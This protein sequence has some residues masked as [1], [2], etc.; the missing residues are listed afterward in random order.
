LQIPPTSTPPT[1]PRID[2]LASKEAQLRAQEDELRQ[3]IKMVKLGM[4]ML[5]QRV[6]TAISMLVASSLFGFALSSGE[7]SKIGAASLFT[8]IVFIPALW[9]DTK[10]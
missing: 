1:D 4:S 2:K 9:S 10:N 7:W 6:L 5:A 3:A 8:L